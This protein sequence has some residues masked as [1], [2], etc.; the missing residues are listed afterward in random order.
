[1]NFEKALHYLLKACQLDDLATKESVKISLSIDG[2]DLFKDRTHVSAGVK[3]TDTRGVHPVTKQ[4]LYC[5][6]DETKEEKI[7]KIQSSEMCCILVIA[8]A[9]DKK[10]LYEEVFKEFYEWGNRISTTGLPASNGEPA[11]LPFVVTHTTDQKASWHLSNR[12]GG[13]KNKFF[14]CAFCPCTKNNLV[15]YKINHH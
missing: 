11:L 8:D 5:I 7:V 15:S 13:C 1:L 2:A 6:D 4:P 3:I 14:F 10:E 9:R 12:G